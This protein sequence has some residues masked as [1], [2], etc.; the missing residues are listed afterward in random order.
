[1]P[2]IRISLR[3]IVPRII[4][5]PIH[6]ALAVVP[7]IAICTAAHAETKTALL[8]GVSSYPQ[9]SNLMQLS[10]PR[11]DVALMREI[12][13][14]HGFA[15]T[16]I[17]VLADGLTQAD[18]AH[19]AQTPT[20]A[21]ILSA[22]DMIAR[23]AKSGDFVVFY[24]AGHG[25]KLPLRDLSEARLREKPDGFDEVALPIDIGHW[26][27][28]AQNVPNALFDDELGAALAKIRAKGA[29]VWAIFDTCHSNTMTRA[30]SSFR[31][32]G[33]TPE[34]LGIPES[35]ID[36]ARSAAKSLGAS[37]PA[38]RNVTAPL[39][40]VMQGARAKGGGMVA[41]FATQQDEE[42]LENEI[43]GSGDH[44]AHGLFTYALAKAVRD[45]PPGATY[46]QLMSEIQ[47][48]LLATN[49]TTAHP[50]AEGDDGYQNTRL[51][52]A[53]FG[54]Q[55]G[56]QIRQWPVSFDADNA[57][58]LAGGRLDGIEDGTVLNLYD[59]ATDSDTAHR[60]QIRVVR[61]DLMQSTIAP[62]G[63]LH[64]DNIAGK[65]ARLNAQALRL[66]LR[67][68]RPAHW[69]PDQSDGADD[70]ALDKI[71]E[72]AAVSVAARNTA[73][74][75][76]AAQWVDPGD[77]NADVRL[78]VRYGRIWLMPADRALATIPSRG[79]E[80]PTP[81]VAIDD[82]T[83]TADRLDSALQKVARASALLRVLASLQ[84]TQQSLKVKVA[85][86][87]WA[88]ESVHDATHGWTCDRDMIAKLAAAGR[89]PTDVS[90]GTQLI[91]HDCDRLILS[92]ENDSDS[93]IQ[94]A[95]IYL[96]GRYGIT[97]LEKPL[98]VPVGQTIAEAFNTGFHTHRGS[99]PTPIG[100]E[101]L[102]VICVPY[103]PE[104]PLDL[105]WLAQGA[106]SRGGS[107]PSNPFAAML[108]SVM[109]QSQTRDASAE[110]ASDLNAAFAVRFDIN[111]EEPGRPVSV[112]GN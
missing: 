69:T 74:A 66:S 93:P 3:R 83:A 21:N 27:D 107:G 85:G 80:N 59:H 11:N 102:I 89:K 105:S 110:D 96:D 112:A 73:Q 6:F 54:E 91:A 62:V 55:S 41:F 57:L 65:F 81:S 15:A 109:V 10:G 36:Q 111:V 22:L 29:F 82:A 86:Q 67:V 88:D 25:A 52:S 16:G 90:P 44:L 106:L 103:D 87:F 63:N 2:D 17:R 51:D 35:R 26:D 104:H 1:M 99:E 43:P 95:D 77:T 23:D 28:S 61:A 79:G 70:T 42:A 94:L 18:L 20:R 9:S 97:P 75:G 98:V 72:Q 108:Q 31:V 37:R 38:L 24:Y 53:I 19:T 76:F 32:R 7:I 56:P 92:V 78:L 14:Q 49:V 71:G 34:E 60:G 13:L 48:S 39:D 100:R 68:A 47:A 30:A 40:P 50:A 84:P 12:L 33:A 46:R 45:A 5:S 8:V 101:H 64:A 58:V 4:R